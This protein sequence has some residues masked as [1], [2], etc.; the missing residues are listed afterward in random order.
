MVYRYDG[1]DGLST[2]PPPGTQGAEVFPT[3]GIPPGVPASVIDVY[4]IYSICEELRNV[5][6]GAGITPAKA[7]VNQLLQALQ[8]GALTF[9]VDT[10][11][12][13]AYAVSPLKPAAALNKGMRIVFFAN[14]GPN[15]GAC[16]LNYGGLGAAPLLLNGNIPCKGKE[17]AAGALVEAVYSGANG[18]VVP[19]GI[20][21]GGA[22]G[23]GITAGSP[24]PA[25]T[26]LNN[27]G[28]GYAQYTATAANTPAANAGIALTFSTD[29]SASGDSTDTLGQITYQVT[30]LQFWRVNV[31]NGGWTA[32]NQ[33]LDLPTAQGAFAAI[34]GS[35]AQKFDAANAQGGYDVVPI[36]QAQS[37]FASL[38]NPQT[39]GSATA[40]STQNL[41][42]VSGT[43]TP[44]LQLSNNI[45][46]TLAGNT[47]IANPSAM[48][49]GAIGVI[50]LQQNAT[51]GYSVSWGS[52]WQFSNNAAPTIPTGAN[53]GI[54]L[55]YYVQALNSIAVAPLSAIDAT[56]ISINTNTTNFSLKTAIT[57]LGWNGS[58]P[59]NVNV[60]IASGVTIGS[61]STTAAFTVESF[62]SGSVINIINNGT[63]AGYSLSASGT[64]GPA[65]SIASPVNLINNSNAI[66]SGGNGANTSTITYYGNSGA[67]ITATAGLTIQSNSGTIIGGIGD[68]GTGHAISTSATLT[69]ISNTGY[70]VGGGG[71]TFPGCGISSTNNITINNNYGYILGGGSRGAPPANDVTF[72]GGA[73]AISTTG[74][75]TILSNSGYIVGGG[76]GGWGSDTGTTL[77]SMGG[78]GIYAA[79][80][81]VA[82][83]GYI[84][85][86]GC[87]GASHNAP[88]I[89]VAPI[90]TTSSTQTSTINNTGTEAEGGLTSSTCGCAPFGGGAS[91]TNYGGGA[92]YGLG[93]TSGGNATLLQGGGADGA[94]LLNPGKYGSLTGSSYIIIN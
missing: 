36:T 25:I 14:A 52:A 34:N 47:T 4:W 70:I 71:G 62:P 94:G 80:V 93:V 17:I 21:G 75:V 65:L 63:I 31:N 54:S 91:T 1:A 77:V 61:T 53:A 85:S 57:A 19:G 23:A 11:T 81:N 86:G 39:L 35:P 8:S 60:Y 29:G 87:G 82:N 83:S 42:T 16:T 64:A 55:I 44:N 84:M 33:M 24:M 74:S 20:S 68:G 30:G 3:A 15:T 43:V 18:W 48:L 66:I 27:A 76:G 89:K 51:G 72:G 37:L 40:F 56:S 32:W 49:P 26:D 88:G 13:G 38:N 6:T 50:T 9:C 90:V 7:Q 5:V 59:I 69:I 58:S 10:G 41:G 45:S 2:P 92:P 22:G 78:A 73:S 79:Y 12:A 46:M 28:L 67:A